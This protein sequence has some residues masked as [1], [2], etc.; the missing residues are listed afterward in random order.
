[1]SR[2]LDQV[3]GS[4]IQFRPR[5]T[6]EFFSLQ[7]AKRLNDVSEIGR[8]TLLAQR[9]PRRTLLQAYRRAIKFGNGR[10]VERFHSEVERLG[11]EDDL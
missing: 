10:V 4:E 1:M 3:A 8:Y 7:L 6:D 11:Q 9:Y 5:T 2:I